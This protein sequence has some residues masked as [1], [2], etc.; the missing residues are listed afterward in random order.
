MDMEENVVK[1]RNED[2]GYRTI[3]NML[4]INRD[5]VRGICKKHGL[6]GKRGGHNTCN[7]SIDEREEMFKIKFQNEYPNFK[8]ISGYK[9]N[10]SIIKCECRT[11]T[12]VRERSAGCLRKKGSIV[13]NECKEN[14]KNGQQL[15]NILIKIKNKTIKL[16]EKV[17]RD[18]MLEEQREKDL[19]TKC[20]ECGMVFKA[21]QLGM[22]YCSRQCSY[23]SNS[24]LKGREKEKLRLKRMKHNGK[25]DTDI[26]LKKLIKRDNN[27]C[28]ICNSECNT[29]DYKKTKEGYFIVGR[30]YP[31]IDHVIPISK[32]GTHTWDNIMLA[33]HYCNTV[34]SNNLQKG[35][36]K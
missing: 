20:V 25:I 26:T 3:A 9:N 34:K 14:N 21:N 11:C 17:T 16:E 15:I 10:D 8:Y 31:S 29:K 23:K 35:Q 33:H 19:I 12:T 28:Y 2:M 18:I 32:N 4:N 5:K 1:L 6:L 24:S 13:C 22:K 27:I 36:H 7:D 30:T